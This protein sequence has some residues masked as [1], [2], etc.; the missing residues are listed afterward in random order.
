MAGCDGGNANPASVTSVG[1]VNGKL[2][3]IEIEKEQAAVVPDADVSGEANRMDAEGEKLQNEEREEKQPAAVDADADVIRGESE[4]EPA[5][6]VADDVA[7]DHGSADNFLD[8][9][10]EEKVGSEPAGQ[11]E[12]TSGGDADH[13]KRHAEAIAKIMAKKGKQSS[14]RPSAP[15]LTIY[16]ILTSSPGSSRIELSIPTD[17][18]AA[19]LVRRVSHTSGVLEPELKLIFRGRLITNFQLTNARHVVDE[20]GIEDGSVLHVV[21]KPRR[22]PEE[23][24]EGG[25][26]EGEDNVDVEGEEGTGSE[27]DEEGDPE[28][29]EG[30]DL[31]DETGGVPEGGA[32][33]FSSDPARAQIAADV[34]HFSDA[35]ARAHIAA[36]IRRSSGEAYYHRAARSGDVDALR[37]GVVGGLSEFLHLA[38]SN[39]WTALHEAVRAGHA[40]VVEYLV[41]EV[42]LDIEEVTNQGAGSSPME[43]ALEHHGA[44]HP[45]TIMVQTL[46]RGRDPSTNPWQMH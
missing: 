29:E 6:K 35:R 1:V 10:D 28:E 27:E 31:E 26:A 42:G 7:G 3:N 34:D 37:E 22:R 32:S 23:S 15:T 43:L 14:E 5:L 19:W 16:L 30:S 20:F 40:D 21:G 13:R 25:V 44:D 2:E 18:T 24:E 17:A 41:E 33:H 39:G 9:T 36:D 45:V 8:V 46:L 12:T 11:E 38:D 4:K